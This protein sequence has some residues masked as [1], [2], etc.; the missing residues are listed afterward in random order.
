MV[1]Q[2]ASCKSQLNATWPKIMLT[3]PRR[4]HVP[5]I[6]GRVLGWNISRT[7]PWL[8]KLRAF[9]EA[10]NVTIIAEVGSVH[11]GNFRNAGNSSI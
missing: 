7:H 10:D 3:V 4:A 2:C 8:N 5:A 1:S 9:H 6:I 11:D